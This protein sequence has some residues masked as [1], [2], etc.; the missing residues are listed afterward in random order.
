[1]SSNLG[2]FLAVAG[3]VAVAAAWIAISRGASL[4]LVN[5]ILFPIL[6]LASVLTGL[7]HV[8]V[9]ERGPVEML[10][11]GTMTGVVLYIATA[12]FMAVAGRWPPL[13][14][15]TD[16]IYG[17]R[18]SISLPGALAV[19]LVLVVPGEELLWRGVVLPQLLLWLSPSP[20]VVGLAWLAYVAANAASRSLPIVLAAIV[21]GAV[22]TV[23][24]AATG[25]VLASVGSHVVWTGLMLAHPPGGAGR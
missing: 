24:A 4:W 25:G 8:A 15:H 22:W 3:P 20:L 1:M 7:V 21:G 9:P 19:S 2:G 12:A 23:L 10:A 17:N 18:G 13:A 16:A 14:R 5:G 6:G 11:V